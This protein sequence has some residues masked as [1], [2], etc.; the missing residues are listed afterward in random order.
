MGT[1]PPETGSGSRQTFDPKTGLTRETA[2]EA[3]G[4]SD[5]KLNRLQALLATGRRNYADAVKDLDEPE[6]EEI[7][8]PRPITRPRRR[9]P[10]RAGQRY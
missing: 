9:P 8:Q 2:V 3:A 6:E 1:T 7:P 5:E 4:L 10:V